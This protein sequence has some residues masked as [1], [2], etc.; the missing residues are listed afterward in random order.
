MQVAS[1]TV[2]LEVCRCGPGRAVVR[3]TGV[4]GHADVGILRRTL[5]HELDDGPALLVVELDPAASTP[6]LRAVLAAARDR[7]RRAGGGL[8]VVT[9]GGT[10]TRAREVTDLL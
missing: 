3:M 2:D 6:E 4:P 7:A 1:P 8:R 5:D 10:G 9:V